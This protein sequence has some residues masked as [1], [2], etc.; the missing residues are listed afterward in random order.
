MSRWPLHDDEVA[1]DEGM[2]E[3][4]WLACT[5]TRPMLFFLRGNASDRKL[6]LY[7]VACVRGT[8]WGQLSDPARKNA[9]EVAEHIADGQGTT[10][11]LGSAH[12]AAWLAEGDINIAG[13]AARETAS[14]LAWHAAID[15][16]SYVGEAVRRGELDTESVIASVQV[17]RCI[18]GNPFRPVAIDSIWRTPTVT[19]LATAA[20]DDRILPAGTLDPDRLAVLADALEDAG[21][22]NDEILTHLRGPGPH[23]RGCWAVDLLLGKE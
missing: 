7:G 1:E 18:F 19:A 3:T 2:T 12:V 20:Y 11:E 9:V 22:D 8:F 15:V 17:L 21:C 10:D 14:P 23:V 5:D 16:P 4:E 6:R 13:C